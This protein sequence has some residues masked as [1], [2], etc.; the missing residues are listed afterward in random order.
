MHSIHR[1]RGFT[2]IELLVVIAIIAILASI[3]FPVFS[4]AREKARSISCTSNL[5]QIG[6]ALQMYRQDYDERS[7]FSSNCG[8]GLQWQMPQFT[9]APYT[10]NYQMFKCPSDSAV[11]RNF[12]SFPNPC[13]SAIP[14]WQ[15]YSYNGIAPPGGGRDFGDGLHDAAITKPGEVIYLMD[16]TEGNGDIPEVRRLRHAAPLPKRHYPCRCQ[17]PTASNTYQCRTFERHN[18]GFNSLFY[19]GHAKWFHVWSVPDRSWEWNAP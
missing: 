6:S 12:P 13:P 19:D 11:N 9:L 5:K 3:L 4:K 1:R 14:R 15:S 16:H 2:L 10:K 17:E 8:A 7:P 18:G